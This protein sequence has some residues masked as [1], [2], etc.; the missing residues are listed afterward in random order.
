MLIRRRYIMGAI[1]IFLASSCKKEE[2]LI[3]A[4]DLIPLDTAVYLYS[5]NYVSHTPQV[6]NFDVEMVGFNGLVNES[7]YNGFVYVDTSY[8]SSVNMD[9]ASTSI[10]SA[11]PVTQTST[12]ILLDL[13][14]T[15]SYRDKHIGVYLRR[16]FEIADSLPNRN[17]ALSSMSGGANW[18]TRFHAENPSE[19]FN[20]SWEYSNQELNTLLAVDDM[21]SS[22]TSGIYL[23][24]RLTGLIDSMIA[25]PMAQGDLSIVWFIGKGNYTISPAEV[26]VII[27]YANLNNVRINV[28]GLKQPDVMRIGLETGGFVCSTLLGKDDI[29]VTGT[30]AFDGEKT[31][32]MNLDDLLFKNVRTHLCNVVATKAGANVWNVG[33]Q[34][35]F[36][37]NYNGYLINFD[38]KIP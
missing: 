14:E 4:E 9:F 5:V 30:A 36:R 8:D 2:S 17:V 18:P 26:D 28:I 13:G 22:N 32:T 25:S 19:I 34:V 11:S 33:D 37:I 3:T 21:T 23:Q 35:N 16:Y 15:Q 6:L 20:N 29:E 38:M 27:N 24:D 7:N 31:G 12:V 1:L 10:V